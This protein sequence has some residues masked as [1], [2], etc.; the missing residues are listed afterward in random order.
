MTKCQIK[1]IN[2]KLSKQQSKGRRLDSNGTDDE[3]EEDIDNEDL[4]DNE[5]GDDVVDYAIN[6]NRQ[7]LSTSEREH[8][9]N[10]K[11]RMLFHQRQH[12]NNLRNH[13]PKRLN[14]YDAGRQGNTNHANL[15]INTSVAT[16]SFDGYF[17]V[18]EDESTPT[19]ETVGSFANEAAKMFSKAAEC[20]AVALSIESSSPVLPFT[21]IALAFE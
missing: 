11:Q 13:R 8:Q 15:S 12:Q 19:N 14:P 5:V 9:E 4:Q 18:A 20:Q 2:G 3:D 16:D 21:T 7:T 17:C 6:E 10:I 1:L